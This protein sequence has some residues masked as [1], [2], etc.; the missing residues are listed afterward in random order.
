MCSWREFNRDLD[1]KVSTDG[2]EKWS[3]C[4]YGG[5]ANKTCWYIRHPGN[6]EKSQGKPPGLD[7]T[8]GS[9]ELALTEMEKGDRFKEDSKSLAVNKV[10]LRCFLEASQGEVLAR[11]L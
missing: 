6:R 11:A 3:H 5:R 4:G 8:T 1:R 10:V 2:A 7:W 9:T